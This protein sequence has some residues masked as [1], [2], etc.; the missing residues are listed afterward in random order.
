[1]GGRLGAASVANGAD[2]LLEDAL[3][4]VVEPLARGK[5]AARSTLLMPACAVVTEG[6]GQTSSLLVWGDADGAATCL[7]PA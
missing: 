1:V 6:V 5:S 7:V 4:G 3:I 2:P